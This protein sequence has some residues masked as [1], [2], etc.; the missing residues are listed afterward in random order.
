[1][2]KEGDTGKDCRSPLPKSFKVLQT[3]DN[4]LIFP[5]FALNPDSSVR[6][7]LFINVSAT[8]AELNAKV[9]KKFGLPRDSCAKLRFG[10]KNLPED[11][12]RVIDPEIALR[13]YSTLTVVEATLQ[14]GMMKNKDA[15][16][17]SQKP[18]A[19]MTESENGPACIA[20]VEEEE[21]GKQ[22]P[23]QNVCL[24]FKLEANTQILFTKVGR[25]I[26]RDRDE[27]MSDLD[28]RILMRVFALRTPNL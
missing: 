16:T 11:T 21:E 23:A 26:N 25:D 18:Q 24:D 19:A 14:G 3:R 9:L 27:Q 6:K 22:R 4:R 13:A 17:Y 12:T 15:H 10:G 20:L 1:V 28:Y 8:F 2:A 7:K 5:L